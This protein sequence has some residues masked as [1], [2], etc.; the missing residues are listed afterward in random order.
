MNKKRRRYD[1]VWKGGAPPAWVAKG[2][3][4]KRPP[5]GGLALSIPPTPKSPGCTHIMTP[6]C[7][8]YQGRRYIDV[9]PLRRWLFLLWG[10]LT[11]RGGCVGHRAATGDSTKMA[12]AVVPFA[13]AA[14]YWIGVYHDFISPF[15]SPQ[16]SLPLPWRYCRLGPGESFDSTPSA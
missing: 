13:L 3:P 4:R 9:L 14:D 2:C 5:A 15:T 10:A 8:V 7:D 6:Q 16:Y 11:L 12:V 1:F